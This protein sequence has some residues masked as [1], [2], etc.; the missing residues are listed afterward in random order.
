MVL[1]VAPAAGAVDEEVGLVP[2]TALQVVQTPPPTVPPVS[3]LQV[4][5]DPQKLVTFATGRQQ[6]P[7]THDPV[8]HSSP[9]LSEHVTSV[10]AQ[11]AQ[12][13]VR[14]AW[15]RRKRHGRLHARQ[16]LVGRR[17]TRTRQDA[18]PMLPVEGGHEEVPPW[19]GGCSHPKP[20]SPSVSDLSSR[21]RPCRS[22]PTEG[23]GDAKA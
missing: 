16:R 19:S 10:L 7:G 8:Q 14:L 13:V 6:L 12:P 23:P 3:D 18:G 11:P 2:V 17:V 9:A 22:I 21:D 15:A 1:P 5:F 4:A 20:R